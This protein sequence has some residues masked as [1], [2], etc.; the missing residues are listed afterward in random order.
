M[1]DLIAPQAPKEKLE[2]LTPQRKIALEVA[3]VAAVLAFCVAIYLTFADAGRGYLLGSAEVTVAGAFAFALL[4]PLVGDRVIRRGERISGKKGSLQIQIGTI[5]VF[6]SLV[7]TALVVHQL[8]VKGAVLE[9]YM[10]GYAA[11]T[12]V[13]RLAEK[14]PADSVKIGNL[15]GSELMYEGIKDLH[16]EQTM[17][18]LEQSLKKRR[19]DLGLPALAK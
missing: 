3:Y 17:K 8:A 14:Q 6:F 13:G 1:T 19:S 15:I 18:E 10:K 2:W 16:D 7:P 5:M 9:T 12:N 11:A 4:F